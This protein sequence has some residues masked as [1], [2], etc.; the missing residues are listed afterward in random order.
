MAPSGFVERLVNIALAI[1]SSLATRLCHRKLICGQLLKFKK[2]ERLDL[3]SFLV[4]DLSFISKLTQVKHLQLSYSGLERLDGIEGMSELRTLE[5]RGTKVN[6][7][8]PLT[9]L[10]NCWS[11]M[12]VKP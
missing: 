9:G 4:S 6:D 2:L 12:Q 8:R 7:L 11:W 1:Q 5:I 10:P 3:H